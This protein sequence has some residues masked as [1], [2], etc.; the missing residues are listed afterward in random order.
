MIKY[1]T[2]LVGLAV[3]AMGVALPMTASAL[4]GG[5]LADTRWDLTQ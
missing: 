1:L 5:S 4:Q 2:A 3:L